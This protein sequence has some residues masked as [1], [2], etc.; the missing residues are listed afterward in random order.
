M[1]VFMFF[2]DF[3]ECQANNGKGPCE[4]VCEN[5]IGSYACRCAR[6]GYELTANKHNCYGKHF[7]V[8]NY[9]IEVTF[10]LHICQLQSVSVRVICVMSSLWC[11]F[12]MCHVRLMASV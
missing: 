8:F 7:V 6:P 2:V 9:D 11:Q 4:D 1:M 12:N 5:Q 3:N 10:M